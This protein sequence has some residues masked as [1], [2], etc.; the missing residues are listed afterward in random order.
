MKAAYIDHVGPPEGIRFG[1]LPMPAVGPADVLVKVSAVCVDPIDTYIR[2]GTLPMDLSFP[3]IIGRDMA[4]TVESAGVA[5]TR[6]ARGDR[7]WCNNQGYHGRQGTFA[8]YVAVNER[9][10]YPIPAGADDKVVVAFAHAGLTACIG[11]QRAG[12]RRGESLFITG[13][14]GN[15]G[16]AVLQLA[17]ARGAR[18]IVTAG[19][20]E[21][22]AWCR[23]LGA[24]R[25]VN[26]R[27]EEVDAAVREFAPEGVD[28][29]W[30][31]SGKPDFDRAVARVARG[32]R[33]IVMA[34]LT[35]RPPFP[36]GPFY[37]RDCSLH[38]FAITYA[39]EDELQAS[40]DEINAWLARGNLKVRIDRVLPL[41]EAATAHRLV[42]SRAP[43]AG[44]VV[45][46]P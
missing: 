23:A 28:V 14:A 41:S 22:L 16:S 2:A 20:P 27:T 5:V 8:E 10:L 17:R 45:L 34:G 1:E 19:T 11:L 42:E 13:G 30:D 39:S 40:A 15:V 18:V 6:F 9:L 44:K 24:D 43:L 32:G 38:G 7:V 21:G 35:A 33:I 25:V 26:Y 29:D 31:T 3:F 36:V 12:L 46:I 4:G 37:T